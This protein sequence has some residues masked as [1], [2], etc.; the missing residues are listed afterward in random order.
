MK[1]QSGPLPLGT[2]VSFHEKAWFRSRPSHQMYRD[3]LK[4]R[5]RTSVTH[6]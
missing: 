6:A 3:R 5:K 4:D 1:A 2:R